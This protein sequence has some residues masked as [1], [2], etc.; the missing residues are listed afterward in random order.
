MG[1]N[2]DVFWLSISSFAIYNAVVGYLLLSQELDDVTQLVLYTFALAVHF[3][4]NDVSL[5]NHHKNAYRRFG[6]WPL[7][8]AVL[9][10]WMV[11]LTAEVSDRV[12]AL[13]IAFLGG[14]IILNVLKDEL[15][16]ERQAR[17]FAIRA[18]R[19]AYTILLQLT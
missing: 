5:R 4:I 19:I 10:G 7:A 14:G 11:G 2:D 13:I 8:A 9:A 12:L 17:F 16:R 3:V 6:R 18:R 15:P 1:T